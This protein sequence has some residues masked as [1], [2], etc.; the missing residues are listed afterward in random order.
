MS[1][2]QSNEPS[3]KPDPKTV[4]TRQRVPGP[5]E[6]RGRSKGRSFLS[7][8]RRVIAIGLL[9]FTL[10]LGLFAPAVRNQFVN[11]DDNL[12]VTENSRVSSGVTW[13]NLKW[14]CGH[15]VAA[16]WHPVTMWSHMVDGQ[17][18]GLN[19]QGHH[20]T[21]MLLHALNA[22]LVFVW[23]QRMTGAMWR[24][25]LVAALFAIHPL[26]VE[27]VAWVAERKDVLSGCFGLLT[28]IFY[29]R[30]AQAKMRMAAGGT[31]NYWLALLFFALGLMS[32]PMLVTWPC[33][34]LLLD[35]WPLERFQ[36][37]RAWQLVTE[38]IPFVALAAGSSV[39]TFLVQQQEGT[40]MSAE[41]LPLGVRSGNA[42]ISYCR[43]LGKMFWPTDLAVFYPHPEHWRLPQV[44]VAGGCL[45]GI[46]V[47]VF[48]RRRRSPFLVMGW[49]WFCGTLVPV[50]GL[51]QVGSQALA[52]RYTYLPSLGVMI[53]VVWGADELTRGWRQRV[54]ALSVT[55]V[56]AVVCCLLLTWQQLRYWKDSETLFRHALAVTENNSIARNGLGAALVETGQTEEAIHQFQEALRLN[57]DF[58]EARASLGAA[59]VKAGQ[60]DEAI[61]QSREALRLKPDLAVAHYNLGLALVKVGQTEEAIHQF[62]EALRL[63]PDAVDAYGNLGT[64]LLGQ[65]QT[66]AAIIQ[67]QHV[68]RLD[69]SHV[70]AH[71]NL[72][73]AL[74]G[75]GQ[76]DAAIIQFQ[77]VLRLDPSHAA[78]HNNLGSALANKG[79]T[80]AAIQ[81][82]Q[83]S[84]RR[85]PDDADAH[86]N[87]G[88][89]LERQ[90]QV[91]AAIGQYREALRL[92]PDFA[93][94]GKNLDAALLRQ[95]QTAPAIRRFREALRR[96]PDDTKA[97]N[98]LAY[99]W[100]EHGENLEEALALVSKAVQIEPGNPGCLDTKGWVLFKLNRPGEALVYLLKAVELSVV[101]DAAQYAHLGDIYAALNQ[102]DRAVAAWRTSVFLN[103]DPQIQKKLDAGSTR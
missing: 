95:G 65:G 59:W 83:E 5:S 8:D 22:V 24:S 32:K 80:D 50:I 39:V 38:K 56:A 9:L 96:N 20:L 76:T 66:D 55:G 1:Q 58:A 2:R 52:D 101:P 97:L 31:R 100:A 6:A 47:L 30:Y 28:L 4:G 98:N 94:A 33:V 49:L 75:Q 42:L 92:K 45:V 11:Y 70:A 61:H 46:S 63:R 87:L 34:M 99:I 37:R 14:A 64:V 93:N 102:H 51:V 74:L 35:Y 7:Q 60:F 77:E 69:P 13:E 78:A 16:N 21:S 67:F 19:P 73:N 26:R 48:L 12:Y 36:P 57:P 84:I 81:Q 25:L 40:V 89:V 17:L 86:N 91:D 41:S 62:R 68:L 82:F 72:G 54:V 85:N 18:F 15:P 53:L 90:G 3:P 43:Y 10:V 88:I 79:Q 23:L 103:P 71:N 29:T 27:S 44:L